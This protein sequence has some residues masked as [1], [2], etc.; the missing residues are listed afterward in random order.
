MGVKNKIKTHKATAKRVSFTKTGKVKYT[1]Q[2]RRHQVHLK[3][4]KRMRRLKKGAYLSEANVGAIK[5]L[6][7][8]A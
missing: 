7:P 6:V 8:Y 4:S 2:N 1:R 5:K 3:D